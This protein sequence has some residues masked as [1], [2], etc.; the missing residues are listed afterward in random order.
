MFVFVYECWNAVNSQ[1]SNGKEPNEIIFKMY[2]FVCVHVSIYLFLCV[3]FVCMCVCVCMCV[4]VFV[5]VCHQ[6]CQYII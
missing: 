1:K 3:F 5:C 2:V 6:Y 4:Q